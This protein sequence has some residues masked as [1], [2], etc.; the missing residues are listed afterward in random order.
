MRS[1]DIVEL[2]I[3]TLSVLDKVKV[4]GA[5]TVGCGSCSPS[6]AGIT[7]FQPDRIRVLVVFAVDLN[8][9]IAA[10][11]CGNFGSICESSAFKRFVHLREW[12]VKTLHEV[13]G[14]LEENL[15][16]VSFGR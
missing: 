14:S 8:K 9:L 12:R 1:Q 15:D 2:C 16:D 3:K 5:V 7:S 4:L 10:K 6:W 13:R 11:W